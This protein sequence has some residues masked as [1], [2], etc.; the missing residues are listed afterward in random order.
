MTTLFELLDT[1]LRPTR[2]MDFLAPLAIRLYLAPVFW[3]AGTK[4]FA[5]FDNTVEWFGN[6][7]WGL[8][9]PFPTLMVLLAATAESLGAILLLLGLFTRWISIPLMITMVVAAVTVHWHNGWLAIAEGADSLFATERTI[10]AI[11]RLDRAK[12]IL[13]EHGNYDWLTQNGSLVILNNGIEFAVTYCI[14]LLTL[15]FIGAGRWFSLDHWLTQWAY[16]QSARLPAPS[17][18]RT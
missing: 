15:Y 4:K 11:E 18:R 7:D 5:S 16:G 10:G 17:P 14:M 1:L 8:G 12:A 9:L 3:M 6:P 2:A 13:Q